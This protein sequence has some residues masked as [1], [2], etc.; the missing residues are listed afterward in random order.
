MQA[1]AREVFPAPGL[2]RSAVQ[3]PA[4]MKVPSA[5]LFSKFQKFYLQFAKKSV[6]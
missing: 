3:A 6:Q 5:K 2:A 4:M 1:P